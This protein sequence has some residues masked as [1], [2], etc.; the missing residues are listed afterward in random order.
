M[1]SLQ[2][3]SKREDAAYGPSLPLASDIRKQ[4]Q[5]AEG[6]AH[7]PHEPGPVLRLPQLHVV[8]FLPAHS[9]QVLRSG[10]EA[11]GAQARVSAVIGMVGDPSQRCPRQP[12]D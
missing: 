5:T 10:K 1:R 3:R 2:V 8:K 6:G 4:R 9:H 11:A 7:P 12:G